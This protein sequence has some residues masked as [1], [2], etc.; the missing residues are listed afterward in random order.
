MSNAVKDYLDQKGISYES[1]S[2]PWT[3]DEATARLK[4]DELEI[5]TDIIFK[6]LVLKGNK[7]GPVIAMVP[8]NGRL[9]YKK[10]A[11]LTGNHKIGFPQMDYVMETTGYPHGANTPIGIKMQHPEYLQV[12][13]NHVKEF[14]QILVSAG[15][16]GESVKINVTDLL[17][18]VD[19][20]LGDI[21]A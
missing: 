4:E 6:T 17:E 11:K 1:F 18:I 12:F 13:D 7:T 16:I 15:E 21:L 3:M 10:T 5:P 9:D 19:P 2:F 20:V 8:L 14:D